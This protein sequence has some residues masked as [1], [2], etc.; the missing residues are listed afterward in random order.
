M[1]LNEL[2][3]F[4]FVVVV[5]VFFCFWFAF[6]IVLTIFF[7]MLCLSDLFTERLAGYF[8]FAVDIRLVKRAS[9]STLCQANGYRC[10]LN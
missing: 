8:P 10:L 4:F 7:S 5:Y 6:F 9:S 2:W 3:V 1:R